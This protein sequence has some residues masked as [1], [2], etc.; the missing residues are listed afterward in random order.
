[1]SADLSDVR[2]RLDYE[3][4]QR[5][6]MLSELREYS[7]GDTREQVD[8]ILRE[9]Q[10]LRLFL[11]ERWNEQQAELDQFK[12][13]IE[14][15]N[16]RLRTVINEINELRILIIEEEHHNDIKRNLLR[17][18]DEYIERLKIAIR[19]LDKK[20]APKKIEF[21]PII[22]D[23]IDALLQE[24]LRKYGCNIPLTRLGG[25]F[26]LFGTRKIFAK[27]MNRQ[28]VVRVG[29]GYMIIDEF[30]A[31]YADMELI[32][33][34]KMMR[35]EDVGSYEELKVYKKY[36]DENPDAFKKVDPKRR[37]IVGSPKQKMKASERGRFN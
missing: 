25:G 21:V 3:L 9:V 28:L 18:R 32:R 16:E 2:S 14:Q 33:I 13:D 24:A 17:N 10:E 27:I 29:G 30:L 8:C 36:R 22:G 26:Y 7:A 31:T 12:L 1:M 6:R 37:T 19:E 23:D 34:D 11:R 20:P 5:E 4:A 15:H 35:N